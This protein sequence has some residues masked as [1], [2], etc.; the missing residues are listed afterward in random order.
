MF[1]FSKPT[2]ASSAFTSVVS[3]YCLVASLAGV[4]VAADLAIV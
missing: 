3:S 1:Y 4:G 2:N